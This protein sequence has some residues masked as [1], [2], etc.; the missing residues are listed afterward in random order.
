MS[1]A[2]A[3]DEKWAWMRSYEEPVVR[4]AVEVAAG[5]LVLRR[6]YPFASLQNLR[7][8][9][10]TEY[11]YDWNLPHVRHDYGKFHAVG[12]S[13][14]VLLVGTLEDVVERVVAA[15]EEHLAGR[16]TGRAAHA[17]PRVDTGGR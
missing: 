14:E 8:S 6:L 11:P 17:E 5:Y 15:M 3:I 9:H 2:S 13:G 12:C 10:G 4:R 7:F 16:C 1:V